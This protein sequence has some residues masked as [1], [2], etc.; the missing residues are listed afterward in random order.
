MVNFSQDFVNAHQLKHAPKKRVGAAPN[1][2]AKESDL[3][4]KIIDECKRRGWL[5][6]HS[7]MDKKTNRTKGEPDF[8]IFAECGRHIFLEAKSKT[9]KLSSEQLGVIAWARKLGTDIHIVSSF[10]E[11]LVIFNH[12]TD[13]P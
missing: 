7:R 12:E 8:I 2:E 11:V 13:K 5:Y 9:G 4:D 10:E 3:H 1:A 6:F